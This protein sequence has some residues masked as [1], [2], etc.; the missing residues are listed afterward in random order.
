MT[1]NPLDLQVNLAQRR[2]WTVLAR[3]D[4]EATL[5][6]P[7]RFDPLGCLVA[8]FLPYLLW[9]GFVM[10]DAIW[11]VEMRPDGSLLWNGETTEEIHRRRARRYLWR[12]VALFVAAL[13]ALAMCAWIV[14]A[15]GQYSKY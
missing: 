4:T 11:R 9:Y 8:G 5:V 2:G 14:V 13:L 12:A 15:M 1:Q 10:R 3:T 7:K 6:E